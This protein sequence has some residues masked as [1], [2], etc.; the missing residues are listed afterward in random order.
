[1]SAGI[2]RGATLLRK[3]RQGRGLS[4]WRAAQVLIV[5]P[6][7]LSRF[8][9]GERPGLRTALQIQERS[10]GEIPADSWLEEPTQTE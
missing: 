5:D 1:M 3:W 8:E 10:D 4:Q 9:R 7:N 2:T 6:R